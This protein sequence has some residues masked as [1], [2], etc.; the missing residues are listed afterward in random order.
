MTHADRS[1]LNENTE[2]K[3]NGMVKKYRVVTKLH[4][5]ETVEDYRKFK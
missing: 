1:I 2:R 3:I 5:A 4:G